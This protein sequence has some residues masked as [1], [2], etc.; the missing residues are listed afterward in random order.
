MNKYESYKDSGVRWIGLIPEHWECIR[1]KY[2]IK[3]PLKYGANEAA[4]DDNPDNPRYIRITDFGAD[5]DL[6]NDTFKSLPEDK[7]NDYLLEEGDLLFAR[8]GATVG[9]TFLFKNYDGRA[10]FAGY[11][12]K[13]SFKKEKINSSYIDYVTRSNYY[14]NWK[15]SIFQQATIQNIGADKYN[16][17]KIPIP[18]D[19]KE[20]NAIAAYLDQKTTEIDQL[21]SKK[22]RLIKLLEEEKMAVINQ[23]VTQGLNRDV[24]MK[25]SGVDW[26]G[27]IPEHWDRI[28][29]KNL[30]TTPVCDGPHETPNWVDEG[31]PFISAEAI[32]GNEIDFNYKRGYISREQHL[33]Y[34]KKS[35]VEFGDIL[36]CKSGSTTGKSAMVKTTNEFG[37]WSPLAILRA[38]ENRIVKDYLFYVLQSKFFRTQV[39]NNWTFGTQPNIGMKALE[40]LWVTIPPLSEQQELVNYM[41]YQIFS[42]QELIDKIKKEI[43]YLKEYKTALISNVVTGKVDVR[44]EVMVN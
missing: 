35:K 2:L 37:I 3:E 19:L 34:E 31:V 16:L 40:N 27:E 32:K 28:R 44:D 22:E 14:D 11:L 38:D 43:N 6:K 26:L 7:A 42:T 10:C 8:S 41:K 15:Q 18:K 1:L 17:L 21:I 13:A 4:D 9:K 39:V 36:F 30:V 5:G 33:E 20:Q 23:A 25:D 12:I 24:P 29:I